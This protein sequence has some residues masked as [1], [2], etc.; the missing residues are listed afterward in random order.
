MNPTIFSNMQYNL[1]PLRF[2]A[3]AKR[4]DR[5]L[6][7]Y[8]KEPFFAGL[9]IFVHSPLDRPYFNLPPYTL[10]RLGEDSSLM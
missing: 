3:F 10:R 8:Y 4:E 9:Q 6:K 5:V 1:L 7:I 2:D